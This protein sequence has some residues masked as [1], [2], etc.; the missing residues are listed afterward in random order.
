V[1]VVDASGA[2]PLPATGVILPASPSIQ[3]L[4]EGETYHINGWTIAVSRWV[5]FTNDTTG[6]GMAVAAQNQDFL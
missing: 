4:S 5:R 3:Q 1:L 6:H 2:S